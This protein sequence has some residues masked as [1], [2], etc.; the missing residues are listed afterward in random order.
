MYSVVREIDRAGLSICC[1]QELRYHGIGSDIIATNTGAAY[2][3]HWSGYKC[4]SE[5]GV[6]IVIKRDPGIKDPRVI[7]IF[8][9]S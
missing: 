8:A 9:P 5:A 7:E 1:L 3:L 6:G 4:K 2:E